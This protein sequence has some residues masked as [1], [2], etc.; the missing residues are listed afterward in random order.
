MR[1]T[2]A[3]SCMFV[4]LVI[5]TLVVPSGPAK[6]QQRSGPQAVYFP[7]TGHH[8]DNQYGF[9]DYWRANGQV[10][11]FGYPVTGV[12]EEDGRP[13]QYFER[14][15][16]EYHAEYAGTSSSILL[17]LLSREL[18]GNRQFPVGAAVEGRLFPET[19]YTVFGKFLQYWSKRGGL[20][21]FG[22]PI[23]ESYVETM[24]DGSTLAVQWFER[25]RLEYHPG[26]VHP[27]FRDREAANGTRIF[28]LYEILMG[29]IG[30]EVALARGYRLNPAPRVAGVPDWSPALWP[31]RIEIDLSE[32]QLVAYE[33]DLPVLRAGVS[34]GKTSFETPPGTYAVYAKLL[35]DDMTGNLQGEEYDVRKVPYVMYFHQGYAIHGTYWHNEFGSG[36]RRSHGCVNLSM[37]DAEW[38]WNWAQ[39]SWDPSQAGRA[40]SY[41]PL[42]PRST[43]EADLQPLEGLAIFRRGTTVIVRQ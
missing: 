38:L 16:M 12:F 9:L 10:V 25:A 11:R 17:G 40:A 39:P 13:V 34:T 29:Q 23:S 3:V 30:R 37:D 28:T 14:A 41:T 21:V 4:L 31:Q 26:N 15:R 35:Y 7:Q 32:Q 33:G 27:F 43:L 42:V 6:A 24:P 36:V 22:Y 1:R 18:L 5:A 19:G 20:A 8:V 2:H